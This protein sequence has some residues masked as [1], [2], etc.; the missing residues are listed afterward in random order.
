MSDDLVSNRP[1][2][3]KALK[4][5]Q[6]AHDAC[7]KHPV[8]D[9]LGMSHGPFSGVNEALG[10][11]AILEA[12]NARL[13]AVEKAKAQEWFCDTLGEIGFV[14]IRD[15]A[16]M[17]ARAIAAESELS[18]L[19]ARVREVVGPLVSHYE[20]WMDERD[21]ETQSSTFPRHT[22]A[23]LNAARQLVEEVNQT[24]P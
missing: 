17:Q 14:G 1:F 2:Y 19:R 12:E 7:F 3:N 8:R 23:Q 24:K 22:F 21:P 10:I 13:R 11:V 15:Y 18:T 6:A 4:A 20:P 5:L 16:A 9:V